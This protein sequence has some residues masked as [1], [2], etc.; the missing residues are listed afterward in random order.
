VDDGMI[1]LHLVNT[2]EGGGAER[3]LLRLLHALAAPY[4]AGRAVPVPRIDSRLVTMR[5]AGDLADQL[6]ESV[7]CHA[8]NLTGRKKFLG[9]AIGGLARR[10]QARVIH[11]RGVGTWADAL[12]ASVLAP[13]CRLILGFH[14]QTQRS[15]FGRRSRLL[16]Q[17]ALRAGARFATVCEAGAAALRDGLGI[18]DGLTDVLPN[19]VDL[20]QFRFQPERRDEV[21]RELGFGPAEFV[22]GTVGSLTP[23]KR[24]DLLLNAAAELLKSHPRLRLLIVGD[25]ALR[26][27]LTARASALGLSEFVRFTGLRTDVAAMLSAMDAFVSASD[28]EC[29]SNAILEAMA[30]GRPI[31]ATDVGENSRIIRHE[32]DGIIVPAGVLLGVVSGLRRFMEEPALARRLGDSAA[33]RALD[34]DFTATAEAYRAYYLRLSGR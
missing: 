5:Q 18:P 15:P 9:L 23:I 22:V 21:R 1:V 33:N 19:G 6:P 7:A 31:L 10:Y 11:A 24:H 4:Q 30:A 32:L 12:A 16:T 25:G 17:V 28:S 3:T 2:L 29:M 20:N 27:S 13:R 8:L 34:Y 26:E 14:G